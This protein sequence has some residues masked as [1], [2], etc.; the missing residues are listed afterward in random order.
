MNFDEPMSWLAE[1]ALDGPV[2][3]CEEAAEAK[4]IPLERELKSLV[5]VTSLGIVTAHVAGDQFLSLRQVK[6]SLRCQEAR[7]A[8]GDV[9][10]SLGVSVGTVTP[11]HRSIWHMRQLICYKVL[12]FEWVSTNS[13]SYDHYV[14]F[15]PLVLLR[16]PQVSIGQFER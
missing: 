3:T 5:L 13:G 6:R 14:V 4:G 2:R 7:L 15:D 1:F 10:N 9:L 16:A 8:D 12:Q 11:F